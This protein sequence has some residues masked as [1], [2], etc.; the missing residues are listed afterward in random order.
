M[1]KK[2]LIEYWLEAKRLVEERQQLGALEFPTG[3][4]FLDEVTDGLRRGEVWILSGMTGSGKTSLALQVAR[5]FADNPKHSILFLTLE[6]KG[7]ELVTRMFC[8]MQKI[9]SMDFRK[10]LLPPSY[11]EKEKM[12]TEYIQ[13]IDFEIVEYGYN[14]SEVESIIKGLYK[15][16]K[17]DVIF[18]D[19][20]QLIEWQRFKDERL[21]LVEYIRKMKELAKRED[22][23]I[24]VVSQIR[25]LPAGASSDRPPE[26]QDLKGSG[27]LEQTADKVIFIYSKTTEDIKSKEINKHYYINLAKNRQG[28][29]IEK[30]VGFISQH[31]RFIDIEEWGADLTKGV[32]GKL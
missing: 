28:P 24:V 4:P 25:R 19:F 1:Q 31:H 14:F 13:S 5:N 11:L 27:S 29:L 20:I 2:A 10:G 12:F 17:P 16:K 18:L 32:G 30:E 21:A 23:G 22:I 7:Y 9:D 6:M 26:L 3:L 15:D 8:E